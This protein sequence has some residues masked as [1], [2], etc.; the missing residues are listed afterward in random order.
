MSVLVALFLLAQDSAPEALYRKCDSE[1]PWITD[2]T[3]LLDA[4]QLGRRPRNYRVDRAA[5][6]EQAKKTAAESKRLILWYCPRIPGGHMNRA[7]VLDNYMKV[8]VFTDPE[9]VDLIRTRFVP[10]R[11]CC[12]PAMTQTVGIRRFDFVEPGFIFLTPAGKLVHKIDRIRTFNAEWVRAV[13]VSVL[14]KFDP[15]DAPEK[16]KETTPGLSLLREDKL[17]EARAVFEKD[18]STESIYHLAYLD[19]ITGR[20][21]APRWRELVEKHAD[22][23]WAWRAAANLVAGHDT[24]PDG[25]MAHCFEDF[26][27]APVAGLPTSTRLP[28][29]TVEEAASGAV[30]FLLR[31]Q[32]GNGSWNDS[33]YVYCPNPR[34]H[35]NVVMAVTALAA[36]AL[37]EWRELDPERIDAARA[38]AETFLKDDTTMNRGDNEECY[39]DAYRLMYFA[40]TADV[41]RMDEVVGKLAAQQRDGS[42]AHEYPNPFA[43]AAAV[44]SLALAKKAGADV[45]DVL[46]RKAAEALAKTRGTGGR[47]AYLNGRRPGSE[48]NSVV[49]SPMCELALH[50]CGKGSLDDVA[51]ALDAYWRG[52]AALEAVRVTDFHADEELGGFFYFHGVF[53]ACEAAMA[54]PEAKR[55]PHLAKFQAQML[56]I[57][58][59]DGSFIDS[60]ELGKSYGT[61]MALLV[62]KRT[63]VSY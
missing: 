13:L 38:R 7:Q 41:Q 18:G 48:K 30:R 6:L 46:F 21:P 26:S 51:S 33:R 62:L 42:W 56:A 32:R 55:K 40:R 1:I 52:L 37:S 24:L 9:V 50:E 27:L 34:I 22:T 14:K 58:E 17:D 44:H 57:P 63:Q 35:P 60:H 25:P 29:K 12:D 43:T 45:P 36:S 8:V 2:G 47:Q 23:R 11:M 4:E 20:D 10:L 39:A 28:A 49:R 54:L 19:S 59:I 5:L 16:G 3:E 61:A 15:A 53:H 31:A